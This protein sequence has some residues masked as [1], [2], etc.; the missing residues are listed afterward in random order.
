MIVLP[1]LAIAGT[2]R[3]RAA[4]DNARAAHR[5]VVGLALLGAALGDLPDARRAIDL[6]PAA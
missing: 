5:T 1:C 3:W 2:A 6:D 4:D